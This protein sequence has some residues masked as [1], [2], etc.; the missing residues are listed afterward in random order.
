EPG[1]LAGDRYFATV[2]LAQQIGD[3]VSDDIDDMKR[4]RLGRRQ[5]RGRTYRVGGPVGIAAADRG[6]AADVGDRVVDDF[7][8]LGV[9]R[10]SRFGVLP[11]LL[12]FLVGWK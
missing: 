6:K 1:R 3:V 9:R 12:R 8:R 2:D 11:V 7:A 4:E 10:F 5:A